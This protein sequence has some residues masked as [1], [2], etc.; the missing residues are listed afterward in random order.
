MERSAARVSVGRRGQC[1]AFH[2]AGWQL[3][4]RAQRWKADSHESGSAAQTVAFATKLRYWQAI[5]T[6]N[7]PADPHSTKLGRGPALVPVAAQ[8][9]ISAARESTLD[10][11][12]KPILVRDGGRHSCVAPVAATAVVHR[13]DGIA[14]FHRL[15]WHGLV[16][17][18]PLCDF[19][20]NPT[21][22][23]TGRAAAGAASSNHPEAAP[24]QGSDARRKSRELLP[25]GLPQL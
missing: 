5:A 16:C 4:A 6:I 8:E 22:A 13:P 17:G 2:Q 19:L 9:R 7:A 23:S 24:W 25:A 20:P 15:S 11:P 18:R 3:P 1:A 10:R 14:D 12:R 21:A